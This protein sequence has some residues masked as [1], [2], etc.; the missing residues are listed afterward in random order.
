MRKL[1]MA[2][3]LASV[4]GAAIAGD[5]PLIQPAPAWV[6]PAPPI[7]TAKLTG[8]SP[9]LVTLDH[10]D[11]IEGDAAWSYADV[12]TRLATPDLVTRSGTLNLPWNPA[13]G[14][15]IVHRVE[16]HRGAQV[17]DVLGTGKQFEVLRRE[18]GMEQLQLDGQLTAS[19][20]IDGLQVGDVLR[21]AASVTRKEQAFAGKTQTAVLLPQAP[22]RAGF[23]RA[24]VL[25][26]RAEEV[27][28]KA[29]LDGA[30]P[31]EAEAG[32]Y[33]ELTIAGLSPK[34]ADLPADAPARFHRP[35]LLEASSF[36]DWA[37]VSRTM[38]PLYATKGAISPG[39]PLAAEVARIATATTDPTRRAA[40][41][42]ELVQEK[43]RYW[44]NGLGNGNYVPQSP[45]RTWASRYGDCK[46]KTLLLLAVLRELGIE[47]EPVLASMQLGDLLPNRLAGPGAFDHVLVRATIGADTYWLDGTG[48]G[49]RYADLGDT[50]PLRWV[51]PLRSSGAELLAVPARAPAYPKIAVKLDLD[52]SAGIALP[53]VVSAAI[54]LRGPAA[55]AIGLAKSQGSEEQKRD[56]VGSI[57]ASL[58]GREVAVSTYD[59]AHDPI[60]AVA[61]V[62]A[63]G[64]A[65]S[66]WR[67]KDGRYRTT[68]DRTVSE[69]S[70]EP[71][72]TR[73]AWRS[74]PVATGAPDA[75]EFVTRVR[76]PA[77][78]N[79]FGLE[80]DAELA[81]TLGGT[82]VERKAALA[83]D[84]IAIEERVT[85]TGAEVAPANV[86]AARAR[87]ALAKA[88]LL[89][90]VAPAELPKRWTWAE[91]GRR[92]GRFK[93]ILAAYAQAIAGNP[94]EVSNYVNRAN[95]LMGVFDWK[96]ALPDLDKAVALD[97]TAANHLQR[98]RVH[99]VLGR[100]VEMV[101][102][103][104]AAL[105][106]EPASWAALELLG[107]EDIR[108]GRRDAA[109]AR[110]QERIDAG[111]EDKD[112]MVMLK[113]ELLSRTGDGAAAV[114][115][116][117]EAIAAGPGSP[118]LLN[119]RCWIKAKH[120]LAL[121]TA[122]KD[123]TRSIELSDAAQAALDSRALVYFR[124]NRMED[125]L[126]DLGAALS[127]DPHQAASL[128]LR[129]VVLNR[130]GRGPQASADLEGARIMAP[131]IA[132]EYK[133]FGV[134][135]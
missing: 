80:G 2:S 33:R 116:L 74:I 95:F 34:A 109:L 73:P 123:C 45:E 57:V 88:R 24:R 114:A 13:K 122:L 90:A 26:P 82:R 130:L 11:K 83:G 92:T 48:A 10:Q 94:D 67:F 129:G 9:V 39:S 117:D 103:A 127:I 128:Y 15:L 104:R 22:L 125:A 56:A 121:D 14:D 49:A 30:K 58:L 113:A 44:L 111:G 133:A 1:L 8:D 36:P 4:S 55:E 93:P 108:A 21:V 32:G 76:L 110:V 98:A 115:A 118:A 20:T 29:Y 12:A 17:I 131:L 43:V 61:T 59:L 65:T 132:A 120:S 51:L 135:P 50:P 70:F 86:P 3:M 5:K 27:R 7:E 54:T 107:K 40:A 62:K 134:A 79:G 69:L 71:D 46:A 97:P 78:L 81:D 96:G 87:V 85:S 41:A 91:Q 106:V 126:A 53:T 66:P 37:A 52:Q 72:R 124:M 28:W 63:T 25:W 31:V 16:I 60:E 77:E 105:A 112:D 23:A 38:A 19:M 119:S 6:E 100:T 101:A 68:L 18:Q 35:P 47:A 84:T 99:R 75:M 42:L 64:L 102:D 89:R